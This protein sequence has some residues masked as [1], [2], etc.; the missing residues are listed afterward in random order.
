M[1]IISQAKDLT[2]GLSKLQRI[3]SRRSA[4]PQLACVKLGRCSDTMIR[5]TATDLDVTVTTCI[6]VESVSDD[7]D[8][9]VPGVKL[10]EIAK[11][12]GSGQAVIASTDK[13]LTVSGGR[14]F[15][16]RLMAHPL[17]QTIRASSPHPRRSGR[18]RHV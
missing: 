15:K 5:A 16:S 10:F 9:L 1:K 18:M 17:G 11:S 7:G 4:L 2:D 12:I 8:I 13:A 3:V 14:N 6:G